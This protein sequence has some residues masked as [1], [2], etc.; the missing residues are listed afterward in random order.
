MPTLSLTSATTAFSDASRSGEILQKH[1]DW[2]RSLNAISVSNP[3]SKFLSVEPGASKTVFNG[4]VTTTV[5][6]STVIGITINPIQPSRY[7]FSY[8]SGTALGIRTDRGLALSGVVLT[9]VSVGN[10]SLT[11]TAGSGTPFATVVVGDS[12][13]IPGL[14]TGDSAGGFNTINEGLWSVIG[15]S[16]TV[17][18]LTRPTGV[19]FQGASE[20]VTPAANSVMAYSAAGVQ[21]GDGVDIT[22]GFALPALKSYKILE[23]TPKWFEVIS[24]SP[25]AVQTGTPTAAGIAFYTES[26]RF[27]RV[28]CD[29]ESA[30]QVNGD[31]GNSNRLS[32]WGAGDPQQVA[33]YVKTGLTWSLVVKNLSGAVANV[34]VLSAE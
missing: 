23:V 31:S 4:T 1:F 16:G 2:R 8:V 27:V 28:E 21:V 18:T 3:E 15:A 33:E 11:V 9:L 13:F 30:V 12:V 26:K 25:L 6:G 29:Q 20:S 14:S 17:L 7:R 24:T 22:I 32:P 10:G 19:S 5:S 34:L